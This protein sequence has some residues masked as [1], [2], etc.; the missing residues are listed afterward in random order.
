MSHDDAP[1]GGLA[2]LRGRLV[3]RQRR[4]RAA[5]ALATVGA[6]A[7]LLALV[8]L[9]GGERPAN[10]AMTG[11]LVAVRLGLAEPPVD[12]VSVPAHRRGDTAVRRVPTGDDRVVFYLV[13]T[14]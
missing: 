4:R 8:F 11:E 6:A 2:D 12:I 10:H 5:G 14:N 7:V 1:P 9:P 13:G 3:R